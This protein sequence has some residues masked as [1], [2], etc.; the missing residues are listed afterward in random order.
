MNE[1][2]KDEVRNALEVY[3]DSDAIDLFLEDFNSKLNVFFSEKINKYNRLLQ[4]LKKYLKT[5]NKKTGNLCGR[6][7]ASR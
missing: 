7:L 1:I 5:I 2:S 6:T 3:F 4:I